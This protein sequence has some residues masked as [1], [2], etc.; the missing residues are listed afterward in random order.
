E[1]HFP[2]ALGLRQVLD[3]AEFLNALR[4]SSAGN[5][6]DSRGST[7]HLKPILRSTLTL[8]DSLGAALG[9]GPII[10]AEASATGFHRLIARS[11]EGASA[12]ETAGGNSLQLARA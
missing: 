4:L 12:V 6:S 3:R 5:V 11:A 1:V 10:A 8:G 2:S 9:L 7:A